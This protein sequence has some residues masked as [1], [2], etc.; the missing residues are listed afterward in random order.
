MIQP[1]VIFWQGREE[2]LLAGGISDWRK[3]L[4][5]RRFKA[6]LVN[7]MKLQCKRLRVRGIARW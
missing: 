1:T 5:N 4:E 3:Q 2:R 6:S 7:L